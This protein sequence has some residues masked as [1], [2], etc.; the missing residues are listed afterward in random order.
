M[1]RARLAGHL[2]ALGGV[3]LAVAGAIQI[4]FGRDIPEWTGNKLAPV[5]LGVLTVVL[6]AVTLLAAHRARLDLEA[7]VGRDENSPCDLAVRDRERAPRR[8]DGAQRVQ[9]RAH[10]GHGERHAQ[11]EVRARAEPEVAQDRVRVTVR[12]ERAARPAARHGRDHDPLPRAHR[13]GAHVVR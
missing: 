4:V 1:T 3:L 8:R 13:H 2:G 10:L 5:P 11:A 12:C 7:P 6:A 9:D